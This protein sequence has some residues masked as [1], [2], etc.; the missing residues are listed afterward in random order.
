VVE[1]SRKAPTLTE[2]RPLR[3]TS[4]KAAPRHGRAILVALSAAEAEGEAP[5]TTNV[6]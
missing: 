2:Q 1:A 6:P 3:G 4:V 5:P